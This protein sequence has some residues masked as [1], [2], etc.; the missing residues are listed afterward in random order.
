M[1]WC[2]GCHKT[3]SKEHWTVELAI[4]AYQHGEDQLPPACPFCIELWPPD[5]EGCD[6]EDPKISCR[7]KG[8]PLFQAKVSLKRWNECRPKTRVLDNLLERWKAKRNPSLKNPIAALKRAIARHRLG[9]IWI[10]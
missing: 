9:G 8:C 4:I 7:N 5:V 1:V 2:P 3:L 6:T 10:P